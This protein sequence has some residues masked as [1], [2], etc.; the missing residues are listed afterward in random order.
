ML[1]IIVIITVIAVT[2]AS[3]P[4]TVTVDNGPSNS[5]T[6]G[7][8]VGT[9]NTYDGVHPCGTMAYTMGTQAIGA[10]KNAGVFR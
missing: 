6:S 2:G 9:A 10:A 5:Y 7:T 1:A 3:D 4:F 8:A